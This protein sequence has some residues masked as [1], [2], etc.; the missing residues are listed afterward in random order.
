MVIA[1]SRRPKIDESPVRLRETVR[2]YRVR[3][4][5]IDDPDFYVVGKFT[6]FKD[7]CFFGLGGRIRV[8]PIKIEVVP[9]DGFQSFCPTLPLV[10]L[11]L[12][13]GRTIEYDLV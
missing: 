4:T 6:S 1:G 11:W 13:C 9:R 7:I 2:G 10:R 5:I 8:S 12:N 3:V